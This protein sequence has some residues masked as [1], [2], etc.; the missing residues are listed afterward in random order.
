[1]SLYEAI[2]G[3]RLRRLATVYGFGFLLLGF[4]T[5]SGYLLGTDNALVGWACLSFNAFTITRL[6]EMSIAEGGIQQMDW[7]R[8]QGYRWTK[9]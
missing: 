7:E 8:E 4:V 1:M 5:S 3:S 2:T 9:L 6:I